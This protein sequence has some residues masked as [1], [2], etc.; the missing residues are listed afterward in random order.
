MGLVITRVW[1]C[2]L[3]NERHRPT[4][5]ERFVV[6]G[7]T[8][9]TVTVHTVTRVVQKN[10]KGFTPHLI[11]ILKFNRV[12]SMVHIRVI[13]AMEGCGISIVER[14]KYYDITIERV[15]ETDMLLTTW[16]ELCQFTHTRYELD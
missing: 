7:R 2:H 8:H 10:D 11:E 4:Q 14:E 6:K 9:E 1:F 5:G 12:Q 16:N 15:I 3:C 13:C